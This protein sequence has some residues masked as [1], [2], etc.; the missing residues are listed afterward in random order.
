MLSLVAVT[1]LKGVVEE[2]RSERWKRA[3]LIVGK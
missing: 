2:R 3:G 1:S